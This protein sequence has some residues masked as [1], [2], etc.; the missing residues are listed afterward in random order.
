[1]PS[2]K[3]EV[4]NRVHFPL[5]VNGFGKG[6]RTVEIAVN[7]IRKN[8]PGD[9]QYELELLEVQGTKRAKGIVDATDLVEL[10]HWLVDTFSSKGGEK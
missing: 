1:M 10:G 6:Q 4:I 8:M 7:T 2:R 9:C 5:G 3:P